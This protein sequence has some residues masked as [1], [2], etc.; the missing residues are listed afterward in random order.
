MDRAHVLVVDD[1]ENVLKLLVRI[2]GDTYQVST[3][4]DGQ[5]AMSL[6]A[7]QAF[8][9]I[10]TD[11]RMPGADGFEV[12]RAAKARAPETEV[13]LMSAYASVQD[14]ASAMKLGACDYLQ[15][16]FDPDD[17]SFVVARALERKRLRTQTDYP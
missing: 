8:D 15:K 12:L 4:G 13:V 2:L 16:P 9:V 17:A 1:K 7:G 3:A 6:I 14:A 5:R 11:L 10:V